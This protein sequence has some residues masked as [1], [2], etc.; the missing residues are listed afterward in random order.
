MN[1]RLPTIGKSIFL[2]LSLF[3]FLSFVR[4]GIFYT[5]MINYLFKLMPFVTLTTLLGTLNMIA[6]S[7]GQNLLWGKIADRYKSRAKLIIAGESIA[8]IAYFIVF[9]IHRS[10]LDMQASLSAGL[11]IVGG[12]SFLEFFWSMSDVGWAALLTDVTTSK[13]RGGI[14][15]A[16]NFIASLGRMIGIFFAGFLYNGGE[17]FRQGTIFYIVIAMLFAS[18]AIMWATSRFRQKVNMKAGKAM[19]KATLEK[20]SASNN[21][22]I[23]KWFLISLIIIVIGAACINQV[24]LLFLEHQEGLNA[25]DPERSFILTAWTLGGMLTSLSCGWLA[26]KIGRIKVIFTGLGLAILTPL[27]YGSM[28]NVSTMALAYGFNGVAFWMMQTVGFAFAGDIIAENRRGRLFGRYNTVMALGWGPAG[29]LVGGPL[30]DIQT[31]NF[32]IPLA[33]A[34]VNTFYISS[35]IVAIGTIVFALKVAKLSAKSTKS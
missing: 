18:A 28:Y 30:T 15:G 24:F 12:L 1:I 2:N 33:R 31:R 27:L 13:T 5:F 22:E 3:Q 19:S 10:L 14:V 21:E 11:A 34:Y 26:D 16:L 35:G 29:F 6:S 4:R 32:G 23:Y 7:L 20:S 25:S 8:A 9:L 17:G